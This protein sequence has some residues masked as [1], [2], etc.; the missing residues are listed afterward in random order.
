MKPGQLEIEHL[1]R[2]LEVRFARSGG[3]GGQHVNKVSTRVTLLLDLERC[4]VLTPAQR[5]RV[6]QQLATRMSRD[7]RLRV[8]SRKSRTQGANR[9]AA[10]QRLIELLR[11]ALRVVKVRRPTGPTLASRERRLAEKRRRGESKR[12]RQSKPSLLD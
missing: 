8:V 12:R 6:R 1:R 5:S 11:E 3:P 9:A 7:G 4:E 10:E 2:W